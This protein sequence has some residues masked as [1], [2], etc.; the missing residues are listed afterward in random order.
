MLTC[1]EVLLNGA[2]VDG[3]DDG[4]RVLHVR[5]GGVGRLVQVAVFARVADLVALAARVRAH[6]GAAVADVVAELGDSV[7]H[8]AQLR[9]QNHAS[10]VARRPLGFQHHL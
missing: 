7:D 6:R 10:S 4:P 1:A 8:V 9:P 3:L 2:L 5:L